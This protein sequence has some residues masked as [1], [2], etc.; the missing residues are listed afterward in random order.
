MCEKDAAFK[1][2]DIGRA[3]VL[4]EHIE[5]KLISGRPTDLRDK[6]QH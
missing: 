3:L 2:T 4:H 6:L 5:Y 1:L